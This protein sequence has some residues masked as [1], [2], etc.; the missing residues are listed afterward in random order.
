MYNASL[1]EVVGY[2]RSFEERLRSMQGLEFVV[3]QDPSEDDTKTEHSGVWVI[4]KQLRRKGDA[5]GNDNVT[6]LSLY[7]V[8]GENVY[9]APS[10]G[11]IMQTRLVGLYALIVLI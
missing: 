3:V 6:A 11:S 10:V 7:F 5:G 9:M 1:A 2:R 4:R 8:V